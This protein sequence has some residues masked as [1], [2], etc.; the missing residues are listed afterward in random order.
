MK[1]KTQ[2]KQS[3]ISEQLKDQI[4]ASGIS[5]YRI[6]KETGVA[7]STISSFM[8]GRRSLSLA[9]VDK[10]GEALGLELIATKTP[11]RE[12]K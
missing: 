6:S 8:A 1:K 10:I 4:E 11:Q 9:N 5:R 7:Q 3:L 12:G 2:K